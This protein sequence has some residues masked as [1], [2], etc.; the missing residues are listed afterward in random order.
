MRDP[1]EILGV[2][3]TASEAEIKK[4]FR[5]L[6]KKHQPHTQTPDNGTT[7]DYVV[8][9]NVTGA[10]FTLTSAAISASDNNMRAPV[11]GIQIVWPSGS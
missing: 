11:N 8:F 2:S 9:T 4:A 6:A 1:Y 5:N 3:K 7:G 10:S